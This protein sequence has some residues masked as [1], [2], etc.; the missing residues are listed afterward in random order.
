MWV[1]PSDP[2][3]SILCSL[4][5]PLSDL[6]PSIARGSTGFPLTMLGSVVPLEIRGFTSW[7][8]RGCLFTLYS[9]RNSWMQ[10]SGFD[11]RV[12]GALLIGAVRWITCCSVK[13]VP[14]SPSL[15]HWQDRRIDRMTHGSPLTKQTVASS[16]FM[17]DSWCL[18][19]CHCFLVWIVNAFIGTD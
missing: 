6:Y 17:C 3:P 9:L 7:Q 5:S 18:C 19:L 10:C 2:S 16:L 4:R 14:A 8:I 1:I 15:R 13:G 11:R 12:S